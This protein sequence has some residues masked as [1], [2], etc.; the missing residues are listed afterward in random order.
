M[1]RLGA[2]RRKEFD[3]AGAGGAH[4]RLQRHVFQVDRLLGSR[5]RTQLRASQVELGAQQAAVAGE[6]AALEA[7]HLHHHTALGGRP[8]GPGQRLAAER[9]FKSLD[10]HYP[11]LRSLGGSGVRPHAGR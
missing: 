11:L 1:L 8:R 7:D 9:H 4:P 6:A 5:L 10:S 3:V 2:Q